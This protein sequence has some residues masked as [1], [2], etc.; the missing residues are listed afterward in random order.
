MGAVMLV[1]RL[2]DEFNFAAKKQ[3]SQKHFVFAKEELKMLQYLKHTNIVNA[4]DSFHEQ[5]QLIIILEYCEY[6]D[7][8]R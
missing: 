4:I 8:S 5:S 2:K 3:L 1:K 6:G 7:L